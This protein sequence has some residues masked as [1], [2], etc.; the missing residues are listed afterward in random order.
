D[1]QEG[2]VDAAKAFV[3]CVRTDRPD[4]LMTTVVCDTTGVALGLV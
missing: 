4:G 2:V 1:E 3:E